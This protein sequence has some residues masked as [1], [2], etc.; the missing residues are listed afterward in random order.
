MEMLNLDMAGLIH[1]WSI[2]CPMVFLSGFIDAIAGGGGLIA[3]PAYMIAG[4][5]MHAV[6][7][8][9]KAMSCLGTSVAMGRYIKSGN[10]N[11]KAGL[12]AALGSFMGSAIGSRVAL[13]IDGDS[14]KR[15][16]VFVLPVVAVFVLAN[17]KKGDVSNPVKGN[18][19][20]VIS[21]LVGAVTGAY[22]GIFGPGAGTFMII[23]FTMFVGLDYIT[24]SGCAK[25][26]NVASN[27]SAFITFVLAGKVI[28]AIALPA[29]AFNMAGCYLGT[30]YALKHGSGLVKKVMI[31]VLVGIFIKL[32]V[33]IL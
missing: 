12:T 27:V 20:Y 17:K 8:T 23:G 18:A 13:M 29:A 21:F 6:L 2:V 15:I 1:V 16:F 10:I 33:D 32:I 25:I 9:N 4:L 28:W 30:G 22:D 7:G 31:V 24:S 11:W 3:T 19:L 14:L 26:V 5:P